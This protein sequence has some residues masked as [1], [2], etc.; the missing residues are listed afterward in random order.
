MNLAGQSTYTV[1]VDTT[2]RKFK[3]SSNTIGGDN[4]FQLLFRGKIES[5][6]GVITV[7]CLVLSVM[8]SDLSVPAYKGNRFLV[9]R[10]HL[11]MCI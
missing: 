11:P 1:V 5:L 2:S 9:N 8:T 10:K 6:E 7:E 3:I 4:I